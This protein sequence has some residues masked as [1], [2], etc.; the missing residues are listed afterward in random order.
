MQS[1]VQMHDK[2]SARSASLESQDRK[3]LLVQDIE[4]AEEIMSSILQNASKLP[5]DNPIVTKMSIIRGSTIAGNKNVQL[6]EVNDVKSQENSSEHLSD[7]DYEDQFG[8]Q[9]PFMDYSSPTK[10]KPTFDYKP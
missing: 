4:E 2:I 1:I 6:Y 5:D 10:M 3:R 7:S 8:I 9:E